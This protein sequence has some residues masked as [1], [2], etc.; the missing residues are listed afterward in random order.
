MVLLG[1]KKDVARIVNYQRFYKPKIKEFVKGFKYEYVQLSFKK[2]LVDFPDLDSQGKK[3]SCTYY[4]S[5]CE[6]IWGTPF[7]IVRLSHIKQ[8]MKKD[9]VRVK[10][11]LSTK[12]LKD[13]LEKQA[14][15]FNYKGL[16]VVI[17]P[18]K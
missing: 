5:W 11:K 10:K 1:T 16:H 18:K 4:E 12:Y 15:A 14:L 17:F 3:H 8:L 7:S 13:L 9:R 6:A 2:L